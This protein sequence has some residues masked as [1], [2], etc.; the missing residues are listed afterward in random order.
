MRIVLIACFFIGIAWSVKAQDKYVFQADSL[1]LPTVEECPPN[2]YLS[3]DLRVRL[4]QFN[5]LYSKEI[6]MGAPDFQTSIEILKPDVYYSV[7]KL[8]KFFCKCMKKGVIKKEDAENEFRSILEKCM[9]IVKKDTTPI[10]AELR[11]TSNP[12]D[13]VGIFDKIE[14]QN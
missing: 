14:I 3:E 13:I 11:A 6:N 5:Q 2:Q 9:L 12:M 7:Q 4:A 10:E 1:C 8:S